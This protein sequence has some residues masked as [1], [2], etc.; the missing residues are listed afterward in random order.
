[1]I[2]SWKGIFLAAIISVTLLAA[3]CGKSN[4]VA[5]VN[6][7][8]ITKQQ[9]DEMVQN[10]KKYYESMGLTI[11]ENKDDEMMKMVK[12]MTLDQ[13]ITQTIL[14]QEAKKAGVQVTKADVD[15]EIAKYKETMTEEKFK[16]TLASNGWSEPKFKD[17]LEK[18][19]TISALQKKL[20]E[21][22]KPATE[23]QAVEYY[24][25]NKKE[26]VVP[27]SYQ[28]RHILVLTEGKEG[29][30][31]KIDL[32]A[33][34]K[35]LAILEQ[36]KQGGDF[37]ELAKQK[38]EDPGSASQGGTFTFSPGDAVPEF[39]AAV[40]ALKPGEITKEPVKTK[41][42]YHIIK[43]ETVTP[44]K[45]K[46]FAEVKEEVLAMLSD[47]AKQDKL[48]KYIEEAKKNS[49]IVNNLDK[50]EEQKTGK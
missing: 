38:S 35:A 13:L 3:G 50:P 22:V 31:G 7:E 21:D 27:A 15:K 29:D 30:S 46:S 1:M 25:K 8:Q 40:K 19:M 28:V 10:M 33:R 42:G 16:Q 45:Q 26:F 41:Y 17:M 37:A 4:I 9:L 12:S 36:L 47:N 24:E 32:E 2:K 34:T 14:L 48:N 44:E 18:D 20:M 11:D 5:T 39:E 23:Q 49:K 43:M 6:G